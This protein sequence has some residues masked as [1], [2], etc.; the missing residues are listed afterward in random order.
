MP[1]T[2]TQP[3]AD[4][5]AVST[6]AT[7][8]RAFAVASL[9]AAACGRV[10]MGRRN[11]GDPTPT[12]WPLEARVTLDTDGVLHIFVQQNAVH[13]KEIS[14]AMAADVYAAVRAALT[15]AGVEHKCLTWKCKTPG[16]R[17]YWHATG[18]WYMG[19]SWQSGRRAEIRIVG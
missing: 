14:T 11:G 6:E 8:L 3:A 15:D 16:K 4:L 7:R 13:T 1:V 17:S 18:D 12:E 5:P 19:S 9:A 10:I 2:G